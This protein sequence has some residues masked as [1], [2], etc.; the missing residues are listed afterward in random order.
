M[1]KVDRPNQIMPRALYS[2]QT[3][4]KQTIRVGILSDLRTPK[5]LALKPYVDKSPSH[6]ECIEIMFLLGNQQDILWMQKA[7]PNEEEEHKFLGK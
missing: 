1:Q 3:D 6:S 2:Y 5:K 4:S 7:R